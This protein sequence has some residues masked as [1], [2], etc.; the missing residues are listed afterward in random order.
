MRGEGDKAVALK[1]FYRMAIEARC[2]I[3]AVVEVADRA[4]NSHYGANLKPYTTNYGRAP[5]AGRGERYRNIM[6]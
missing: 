1:E 5:E 4:T 3:H 6:H 2:Q